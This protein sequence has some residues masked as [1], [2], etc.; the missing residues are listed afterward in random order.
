MRVVVGDEPR[1]NVYYPATGCLGNNLGEEDMQL[2]Q[3]NKP[4]RDY[5]VG[6]TVQLSIK[7]YRKGEYTIKALGGGPL[8]NHYVC[9]HV[10]DDDEVEIDI[11]KVLREIAKVK[12]PTPALSPVIRQ[13]ARYKFIVPHTGEEKTTTYIVPGPAW[14]TVKQTVVYV[15]RI[16]PEKTSFVHVDGLADPRSKCHLRRC[17]QKELPNP[18]AYEQYM[19]LINTA[20]DMKKNPSKYKPSA[21]RL[22][23]RAH[24]TATA[25]I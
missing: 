13:V 7:G 14:D 6:Q 25:R 5:Y 11:G 9:Q 18:E 17:T 3:L 10:S 1:Y 8:L 23:Q 16:D 15:L 19:T 24:E 22:L 12:P 2:S 4:K 21:V 20:K